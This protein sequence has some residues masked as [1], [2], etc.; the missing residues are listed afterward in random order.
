MLGYLNNFDQVRRLRTLVFSSLL[1]PATVLGVAG[2]ASA[3]MVLRF[4]S[5]EPEGIVG[6]QARRFG[7]ALTE[8]TNGEI[9][10]EY[11]WAGSLLPGPQMASGI[12]DGLADVGMTIP[13][14]NP[15]E[16]PISNWATVLGAMADPQFPQNMLQ[17]AAASAEAFIASPEIQQEFESQ[18][19]VM[20]T[21][22]FSYPGF[23]LLCNT[24]VTTLE[25]ARGKRVRVGGNLWASEGQK[26]GMEP[27]ALPGSD[28][29]EAAQRGIVDCVMQHPPGFVGNSVWEVVK[30]YTPTQFTGWNAAFLVV[31]QHTW[32]RLDEA[33]RDAMWEAAFE[34]FV[35]THE[36]SLQDYAVFAGEGADRHDIEFHSVGD[37]LAEA[38]AEAQRSGL[39]E[40]IATA[41]AG[42]SDPEAFVQSYADA[43]EKWREIVFADGFMDFGAGDADDI[44]V[45]LA[46][47]GDLDLSPWANRVREDIFNSRSR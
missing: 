24:P 3:E 1:V 5:F 19:L 11:Y 16:F 2:P 6:Y 34:Y 15:S 37:D 45:R 10:V 35:A 32:D 42:L 33:Q 12:A 29:Y 36:K 38:I 26:V 7:D 9:T 21:P 25:Q 28:V 20:L 31:G 23:D 47:A 44:R 43:M 17:G 13:P 30:H 22:I 46:A 4:T 39:E 14:Y 18:G 41:P 8:A 27:V 40:A